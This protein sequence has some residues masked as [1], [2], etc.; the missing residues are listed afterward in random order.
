M[1]VRHEFASRGLPAASRKVLN[2]WPSTPSAKFEM[3][4][5]TEAGHEITGEPWSSLQ[6][7]AK[8]NK[9][10]LRSA[11]RSPLRTFDGASIVKD[12]R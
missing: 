6:K 8:T 9:T 4:G 7:F 10:I 5:P 12:V 11:G 1:N 2:G 3:Q